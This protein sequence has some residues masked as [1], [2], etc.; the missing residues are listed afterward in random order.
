MG[1]EGRICQTDRDRTSLGCE[2]LGTMSLGHKISVICHLEGLSHVLCLG[3]HISKDR[4]EGRTQPA[5]HPSPI[6]HEKMEGG[7][8]QA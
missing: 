6:L 2:V 3:P 8:G 4:E 1:K 5:E 7:V